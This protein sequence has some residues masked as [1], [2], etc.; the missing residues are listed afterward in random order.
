M[1][2]I[3]QP[4]AYPLRDQHTSFIDSS[5]GPLSQ[6][7]NVFACNII[8]KKLGERAWGQ[9]YILYVM[10]CRVYA[11]HEKVGGTHVQEEV[12]QIQRNMHI[13]GSRGCTIL[14]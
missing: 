12:V 1:Q 13:T 3:N 6:L 14:V 7:F 4:L 11:L 2:A 5:P 8:I 9:G 10:G